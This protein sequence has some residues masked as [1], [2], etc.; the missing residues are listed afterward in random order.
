M[1]GYFELVG[2]VLTDKGSWYKI[3]LVV[4]ITL[5]LY[6][7]QPQILVGQM[8]SAGSFNM[9]GWLFYGLGSLIIYGFIVQAMSNRMK[10]DENVLP[11]L[12]LLGFIGKA[13]KMVPFNLIWGIY[14]CLYVLLF[15]LFGS[16]FLM[17]GTAG[18]VVAGLL[19][20]PYLLI[21]CLA[22]PVMIAVHTK[23]FMYRYLVNP[24]NALDILSRVGIPVL[25]SSLASG[26][27]FVVLV[28]VFYAALFVLGISVSS[29][30]PS[31]FSSAFEIG[32]LVGV[33]F[34]GFLFFYFVI[35]FQFAYWLRMADIAN[36]YLEDTDYLETDYY[37]L[38]EVEP[39]SSVIDEN[40]SLED[41][42]DKKD[43]SV[44]I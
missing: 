4:L 38:D 41:L 1:A 2:N 36:E 37:D 14:M 28:L 34:V 27:S 43:D 30:S 42:S 13:V 23:G 44:D 39:S 15:V 21:A 6:L 22:Y 11:D 18:I 10:S 9:S 31:A 3:S 32:S 17:R 40:L 20:I 25:L 35:V 16:G 24:L 8:L 19:L 29:L 33:L 26:L 12:D 5:A 7:F